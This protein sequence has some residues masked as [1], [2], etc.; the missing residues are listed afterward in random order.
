MAR[1]GGRSPW[2]SRRLKDRGGALLPEKGSVHAPSVLGAL[3]KPQDPGTQDT[4]VNAF[5]TLYLTVSKSQ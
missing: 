3:C 1:D 4:H 2:S 5:E